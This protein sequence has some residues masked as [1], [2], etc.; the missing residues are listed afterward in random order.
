MHQD[1]QHTVRVE[2][3][4]LYRA[5]GA[6]TAPMMDM[7]PAEQALACIVAGATLLS[8]SGYPQDVQ[9]AIWA[10]GRA[11]VK[12]GSGKLDSA[13]TSQRRTRAVKRARRKRGDAK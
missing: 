9:E 7:S 1:S 11:I 12:V 2:V 5:I 13:P 8:T 6:L 10:F 3:S 4:R